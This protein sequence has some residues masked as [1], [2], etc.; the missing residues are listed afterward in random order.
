MVIA[1]TN[2]LI[3]R[4]FTMDDAT[5]MDAV[6]FDPRV[7]E[8][9][10]VWSAAQVRAWLGEQIDVNYQTWRFGMWAVVEKESNHVIGYCGLS[11]YPHRCA[12]PDAEIGYRFVPERWGHG[13]ATEAA[14]SVRDFA[15]DVLNLPRLIA[16]IDPKNARSIRVAEKIGLKYERDVMLDGY[17]HPDRLFAIRR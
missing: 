14:A 12:P 11:R 10:G 9:G 3:L 8:F 7:M 15:F 4:H 2:R 5:S 13:L 6:L 17:D 1:Q 16:M